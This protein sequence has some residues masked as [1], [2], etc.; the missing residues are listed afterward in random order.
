MLPRA[1]GI[2]VL[3]TAVGTRTR[4]V[5]GQDDKLPEGKGKDYV[6]SVCQQCHGL[7]AITSSRRSLDEWRMVVN[8][9]VSQGAPLQDDEVEIVS[10]YLAKNFGPEKSESGSEK[11][12]DDKGN[13]A[14]ERK[15]T[16]AL[17]VAPRSSSIA[18]KLTA[19]R[20]SRDLKTS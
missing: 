1:L 19:R 5:Q 13:G 10:E 6:A 2:L 18:R 8:D 7:E 20:W 4:T 14:A 16:R 9:M 12:S 3:I 15:H 17:T 11:K